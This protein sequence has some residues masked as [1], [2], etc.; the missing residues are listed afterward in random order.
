MYL[1]YIDI[2]FNKSFTENGPDTTEDMEQEVVAAKAAPP[3][4]KKPE[5]EEEGPM[6]EH[7]NVIFIGHVGKLIDN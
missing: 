3:P 4:K 2:F 1:R 6:K 7:V 5:P